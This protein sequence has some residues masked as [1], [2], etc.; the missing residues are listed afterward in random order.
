[1]KLKI[2]RNKNELEKY[3]NIGWLQGRPLTEEHRKNV[4]LE[5]KKGN[6]QN[7]KEL[8]RLISHIKI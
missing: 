2:Y 1:M 8:T 4:Q 6:K 3:F 7:K 5:N